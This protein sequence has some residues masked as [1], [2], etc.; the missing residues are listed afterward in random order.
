VAGA[1]R[2]QN[3]V[4][5]PRLNQRLIVPVFE[6]LLLSHLPAGGFF[7]GSADVLVLGAASLGWLANPSFINSLLSSCRCKEKLP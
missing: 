4:D 2:Q 1:D 7:I 5:Q 6:P 3:A